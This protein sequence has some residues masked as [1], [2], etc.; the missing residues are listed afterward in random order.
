[1]KVHLIQEA[2]D[3]FKKIASDE[4]YE[5]W[6]LWKLME[7]FQENWN[8]DSSD[9]KVMF[10]HC[11]SANSELWFSD[12]YAP[13][14]SMLRYIE[15]SEDLVRAMFNDL[16][17]ESKEIV[18][19]IGRF[20]FQCDQFY[21]LERVKK[22]KAIPH[23]HDKSMIF[24]YLA[25]RYPDQYALFN[26]PKFQKFMS[27]IGA[28]SIPEEHDTERFV[29]ACKTL[30]TLAKKDEALMELMQD[31]TNGTTGI[32]LLVSQIYQQ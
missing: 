10:N 15:Q 22:E 2:F 16:F 3:R 9:F 8:T 6:S 32:Q 14:K 17:N 29:K 30:G 1:M 20:E 5:G 11:L 21:K 23:Y 18:G 19:R 12:D 27:N 31:K 7:D 26:F 4:A 13:K 25:F 28:K 24:T